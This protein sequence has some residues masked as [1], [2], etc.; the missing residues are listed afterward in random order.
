MMVL[1]VL[2]AVLALATAPPPALQFVGST[3]C[4]SL[5]RRF[6]GIAATAE[7]ERISWD[8]TFAG[9]G[10]F[11]LRSAYGMQAVNS[12]GFAGGGTAVNVRGIWISVAADARYPKARVYRLTAGKQ[13]LDFIRLDDNLLHLLSADARLMVGNPGW[14]Y[15]LSRKVPVAAPQMLDGLEPY[16]A[17]RRA[18]EVFEGRTPCEALEK[19]L[20]RTRN[21]ECAKVKWR[22]TFHRD[23][24]GTPTRYVLEGF[25]YRNPPRTGTWTA[26]HLRDD[27]RSVVIRLDRSGTG[28]FL[29]FVL[30][31]GNILLFVDNSGRLMVGDEYYSYTL[32][33]VR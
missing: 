6:L 4:D 30:R 24:L 2:L 12:P 10:T 31:D 16:T 7:C 11:G 5:P 9:D 28:H 20:G 26:G 17:P 13:S 29:R 8:V 19:D 27:H 14:S 22:L 25:G 33:R 23:D 3:P 32:N 21:P 15:T 18:A 1:T